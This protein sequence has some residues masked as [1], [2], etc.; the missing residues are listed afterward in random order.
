VKHEREDPRQACRR[1]ALI[2]GRELVI[3]DAP[4]R[5]PQF[6]PAARESYHA[7]VRLSMGRSAHSAQPLGRLAGLAESGL[8]QGMC[9]QEAG[10]AIHPTLGAM[11]LLRGGRMLRRLG[12]RLDTE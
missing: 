1:F 8:G 5:V 11:P 7:C 3:P 2:P 10:R 6:T 12:R 4:A 9:T